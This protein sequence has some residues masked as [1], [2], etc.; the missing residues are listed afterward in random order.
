[1]TETRKVTSGASGKIHHP[2]PSG[3]KWGPGLLL[4]VRDEAAS[5]L[6]FQKALL[7]TVHTHTHKPARD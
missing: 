5:G 2:D 6:G 1:M 4:K 3:W 7:F